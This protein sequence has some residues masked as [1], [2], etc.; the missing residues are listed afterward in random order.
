MFECVSSL[1]ETLILQG[2]IKPFNM[3][4]VVRGTNPGVTMSQLLLMQDM[5]ESNSELWTMIGL[6]HRERERR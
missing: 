4:V 3:S 5:R 1:G 2:T 6:Y